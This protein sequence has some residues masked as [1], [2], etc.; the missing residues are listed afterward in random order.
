MTSAV[1]NAI[2]EE[3]D[4]ATATASAAASSSAPAKPKRN[5]LRRSILMFGLPVMLAVG[6]SYFWLTGGRYE[7]TDNAYVHQVIVSLSSDVAGRIIEVDVAENQHVAAGQVLFRID[8]DPYRI[9]AEQAEAALS[10]A[11]IAV[12]Q[13]RVSYRTALAKLETAK[14]TLDIRQR[15]RERIVSLTDK[16]ISTEA[17][18]DTSLLE[19]ETARSSVDLAEQ[20]V[21]SAV[22]ALG[23]NPDVAT[24]DHPSVKAARAALD[25]AKRNLAK[26][27]VVAPAAGIVSEVDSLN[28]GQM[29]AAGTEVA[30]LVET[31]TSWIEANFKETQLENMKAGQP[32]AVDIDTFPG[33][34]LAG[35]VASIG[36]ATGAEFSLIPAQNATGNWVKVVQRIPVR[37]EIKDFEGLD[38]RTGMSANVS[39]DTGK[40]LL[41]RLL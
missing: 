15:A 31:G 25:V 11:R 24:D 28:V 35:T 8:P 34:K 3:N 33:T 23:G 17:A 12:D 22:A 41:D 37:I 38:L 30:S 1:E 19:L 7:A 13:L 2:N 32:V 40:S 6:G 27:T 4:E 16:G 26:T 5:G 29:L 9:A 20:A 21:Q 14:N 18:N 39:V 36:A 10:N